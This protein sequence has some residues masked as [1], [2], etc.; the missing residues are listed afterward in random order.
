MESAKQDILSFFRIVCSYKSSS[1][2]F[3]MDNICAIASDRAGETGVLCGL[4][5][6]RQACGN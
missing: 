6:R 2:V 1:I 4:C 5:V 3:I